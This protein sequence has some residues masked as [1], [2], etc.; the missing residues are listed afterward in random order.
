MCVFI[1]YVCIY[2]FKK[3]CKIPVRIYVL[4][5]IKKKK[6]Q[7]KYKTIFYT[8]S[9]LVE[10]VAV[11]SLQPQSVMKQICYSKYEKCILLLKCL[12]NKLIN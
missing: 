1:S 9:Y 3:F 6:K 10:A 11:L 12:K 7:N 2:K 4:N 5:V 8:I